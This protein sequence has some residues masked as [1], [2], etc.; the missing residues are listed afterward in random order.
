MPSL[1]NTQ[2]NTNTKHLSPLGGAGGGCRYGLSIFRRCWRLR[3]QPAPVH[4]TRSR[5]PSLYHTPL[6][7]TYPQYHPCHPILP[8]LCTTKQTL[9]PIHTSASYFKFPASNFCELF[10]QFFLLGRL[11]KQLIINA[12]NQYTVNI[13]H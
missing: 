6:C 4:S 13:A 8:D 9:N 12:F 1:N 10:A 3:Q 11:C 7:I 2:D 5:I